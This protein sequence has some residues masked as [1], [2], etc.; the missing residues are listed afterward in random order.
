[1]NVYTTFW[2]VGLI[3]LVLVYSCNFVTLL[4]IQHLSLTS[5]LFKMHTHT[6]THTI[7]IYIF[8]P[9]PPSQLLSTVCKWNYVYQAVK[10]GAIS[11]VKLEFI[12]NILN[13]ISFCI[14]R[15][16]YVKWHGTKEA[17][18]AQMFCRGIDHCEKSG[19]SQVV[20]LQSPYSLNWILSCHSSVGTLFFVGH[21]SLK[22]VSGQ[23]CWMSYSEFSVSFEVVMLQPD[24][25][26]ILQ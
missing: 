3:V 8:I 7:Y 16:W 4:N 2:T 14:I 10:S 12:S 19:W 21:S 6:H 9:S 15:S 5:W 11:L 13:L 23:V 20:S 18:V 1:M 26:G 17:C 24:V 25:G 22:C